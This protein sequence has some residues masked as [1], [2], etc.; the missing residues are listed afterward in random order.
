MFVFYGLAQLAG[1]Q[2][3]NADT[4]APLALKQ[5]QPL[6]CSQLPIPEHY[7]AGKRSEMPLFVEIPSLQPINVGDT[8]CVRVII[9]ANRVKASV[10]FAPFPDTPWDSILLDM[11]G[12]STGISVPVELKRVDDLRNYGINNAHIYE[13]DVQ[14]RDADLYR[15]EGYL[16]YRDAKWNAEAPLG[17]QPFMPEPLFISDLLAIDVQDKDKQSPFSLSRYME[18]PVC[19]ES[20]PEGRWVSIDDIPFDTSSLPPPDN[21]NRVWLPYDCRL[22]RISYQSFAQCLISKYPTVHFFGDSNMRRALK[23]ITTLGEWCSTPQEQASGR[24]LCEDHSEPF[25]RFNL[26]I[27]DA[28]INMDPTNGGWAQ[29]GDLVHTRHANQSRIYAHRWDGL[30]EN[31]QAPWWAVFGAGME[32]NGHAQLVIISLTNWD[33]AFS[34]RSF[35]AWELNRLLDIIENVYDPRTE[36]MVR[37]GQYYCCRHDESRTKRRYSRLR[38]K[39]F[40]SYIVDAFTERF[41]STRKLSIWDVSALS[42]RRPLEARKE[43][44]SCHANHARAEIIEIENQLLFNHMCN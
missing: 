2:D 16:E 28:H 44:I 4:W 32:R 10:V 34:T 22:L 27:R 9:P 17:P 1:L 37:T 19:T 11:V 38:N 18:L 13:A 36:I 14:L 26:N 21:H 43:S 15:P 29:T 41:N 6:K 30:T 40:D 42:E 20:N 5:S 31:N 8:V 24:C 35:Y 23:K 25:P 39:A 12:N 3:Y 33:A 7:W